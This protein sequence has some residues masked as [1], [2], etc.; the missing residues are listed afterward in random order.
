[1]NNR[2][3]GYAEDDIQLPTLTPNMIIHGTNV[4]IP[5]GDVEE[6]PDF[7]QPE[8]SKLAKYLK[9][10]K[11]SL[12]RRWKDEYLRALRERHDFTAGDGSTISIGDVVLIKDDDKNRG[13]WRLGLV[14][15]LIQKDGVT[16]G[17]KLKT[18]IN[19]IIE[20][21]LTHLYPLELHTDSNRDTNA[22]QP[23]NH[24]ER[25]QRVAK[26]NATK[27]IKNI[28]VYESNDK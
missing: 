9:K 4:T 6:D 3:L 15:K 21:S 20:R 28:S 16:L 27:T 7:G 25:V 13:K 14:T 26:T 23:T 5:E 8:P 17:A 1:M 11:D 19:M 24:P 18:K 22:L 10:C 12:W 2:P